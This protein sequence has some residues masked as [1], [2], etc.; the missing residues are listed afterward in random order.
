MEAC[1]YGKLN[2]IPFQGTTETGVVV[3]HGVVDVQMSDVAVGEADGRPEFPA[4][5][6]AKEQLGDLES[7]KYDIFLLVLPPG[8]GDWNSY[9]RGKWTIYNDRQVHSVSTQMHEV[10][11][12]FGL[13]HAGELTTNGDIK[14][15]G[16]T[17][18]FMG[19]SYDSLENACYNPANSYKL[20]W[21]PEQ[22]K[23]IDPFSNNG[24]DA[25]EF[26]LNGVA[27]YKENKDA[28]IVLRLQQLGQEQDY[29]I[30]YNRQ[31]GIN[32]DTGEDKNMVT[33]VRREE[34]GI[35]TKVGKLLP[36]ESYIIKN[37]NNETGRNVEIK[38]V[39][40]SNSN[41]LFS[42]EPTRDAVIEVIASRGITE[43]PTEI[44][45]LTSLEKL[46][47][48]LSRLIELPSEIGHLTSL[49]KL[50][51]YG[52]YIT[53]LPT[54]IGHLTSLTS[55]DL[56]FTPLTTLPTQICDLT[57]LKNLN[58]KGLCRKTAPTNLAPSNLAPSNLAPT[59]LAPK[60][61]APTNLA[62]KDLAPSLA[63]MITTTASSPVMTMNIASPTTTTLGPIQ[64]IEDGTEQNRKQVLLPRLSLR[65]RPLSIVSGREVAPSF[66]VS[67]VASA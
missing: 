40:Y 31:F 49:K 24:V 8:T 63:P 1:S 56:S 66:A 41:D 19:A 29:Y 60:I 3:K 48:Y 55:L 34:N 30:G 57:S 53:E 61:L 27:N 26:T 17:S 32:E 9:A 54:E 58:P 28:L 64:L 35:S 25:R 45:H 51:L 65:F 20:G 46:D 47:L 44:G 59:N 13:N 36:N 2:I 62:P 14:V 21:Y 42:E 67:A 39:G 4:R 6:A 23:T 52:T 43:L 37:F 22:V 11:H 10:G 18:G 16:D 33:I 15:Y 38:F 5:A 50:D 12:T 7:D